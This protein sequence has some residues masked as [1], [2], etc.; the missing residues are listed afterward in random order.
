MST[1][2]DDTAP[3]ADKPDPL[4]AM[5]GEAGTPRAD[6]STAEFSGADAAAP[7]PTATQ[8]TTPYPED[9]RPTA[10]YP[11]ETGWAAGAAGATGAAGA[12]PAAPAPA[13]A[14]AERLRPRATTIVWGAILLVVAAVALVASRIE[15][16]LF[17]PAF[18]I[19]TVVG[20]GALL[21]VGGIV[22]AIARAV[23]RS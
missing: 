15:P 22:G 1:N 18:A 12:A 9:T 17:T 13:S 16:D 20:L 11:T 19:W 23:S 4:T 10:A 8:P 3:I 21:V 6:A 14:T 5:F 7:Q 2:N